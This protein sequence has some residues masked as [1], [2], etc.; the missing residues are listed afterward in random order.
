M[1]INSDN[2]FMPSGTS[3]EALCCEGIVNTNIDK[4]SWNEKFIIGNIAEFLLDSEINWYS[5]IYMLKTIMRD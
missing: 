3:E 1:I 5:L 4:I 2:Y